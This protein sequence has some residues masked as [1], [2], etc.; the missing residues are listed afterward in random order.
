MNSPRI[1]LVGYVGQV[2]WE[3][4]RTLATLATVVAIDRPN[5][6][7]SDPDSIRRV[8]RANEPQIIIN[9]AAYTAVDK[10]EEEP[11]LA[12]QINA[13]APAVM[14]EEAKRL[15][16]AFITYST[17]Y[18]FDGRKS[19]SYTELDNPC[20]LSEY[21]RTKAE[22]D[23]SVQ[24]M[25]GSYLIFRT[26]WVYGSRGKNF[27]LTMVKL[28]QERESLRIV[29][30]QIGAPTWSRSLAEATSQVIA[31]RISQVPRSS[32]RNYLDAFS[33]VK[34]IY[35]M[36]SRGST[37]WYGF[38]ETI[39]QELASRGKT[40]LAHLNKIRSEDY[41]TPA[42]RPLNSV[43]DNQKLFATFG[44]RLPEWKHAAGLVMEDV[45]GSSF[46]S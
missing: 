9:A 29:G 30:D 25:G 45:I 6:E 44:I 18:V 2:G 7:L 36:T 34:G 12:R 24:S 3:L 27:L 8:V 31:Q 13:V 22:G 38:A 4:Q 37:S 32:Q 10:A 43:L 21:G 15:N 19:G 20:P 40:R 1:L 35:N 23:N 14:A 39:S 42:R 16:A 17:D 33:D 41:L 5:I 26:S 46:S 28:L 11:D